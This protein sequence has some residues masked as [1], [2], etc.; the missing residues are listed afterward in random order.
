MGV[1]ARPCIASY[2]MQRHLIL[3]EG[4]TWLKRYHP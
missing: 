3:S 1:K 2:L 4:A